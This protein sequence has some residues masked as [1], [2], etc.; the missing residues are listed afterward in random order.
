MELETNRQGSLTTPRSRHLTEQQSAFALAFIRTN[1][2]ATEA[3]RI[4]GCPNPER[5]GSELFR[6]KAVFTAIQFEMWKDVIGA[7]VLGKKCLL[8][9][10][11][12]KVKTA[13]DKS[14]QIQAVKALHARQDSLQAY[15]EKQE[16]AQAGKLSDVNPTE[17]RQLIAEMK[18]HKAR[19]AGIIE[20]VPV[21][22]IGGESQAIDKQGVSLPLEGSEPDP[23]PDPAPPPGADAG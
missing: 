13:A 8:D 1:G 9:I 16:Q 15:F 19:D 4:A 22:G 14:V 17:L 12:S 10:I 23:D 7:L 3:A 20:A 18:A 11:K 2:N 5:D 21:N 6:H